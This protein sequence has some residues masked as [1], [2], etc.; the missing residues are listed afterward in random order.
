MCLPSPP[1]APQAPAPAPIVPPDNSAQNAL[2][3]QQLADQ[4]AQMEALQAANQQSQLD[5]QTAAQMA[6]A[7]Q[8]RDDQRAQE[9]AD[10][11]T[12]EMT[13]DKRKKRGRGSM[14]IG[15]GPRRTG[16]GSSSQGGS[17]A[18]KSKKTGQGTGTNLPG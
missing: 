16:I 11:S 7:R 12:G 9:G 13:P 2:L 8:L 5:A 4:Q 3:M 10:P 14:V 18:N 17:S 6:A 1:S 15:R